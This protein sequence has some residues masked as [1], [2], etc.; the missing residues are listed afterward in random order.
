VTL[1]ARLDQYQCLSPETDPA[2]VVDVV[3]CALVDA[4][5]PYMFTGCADVAE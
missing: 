1:V 3:G 2:N 4:I 5:N